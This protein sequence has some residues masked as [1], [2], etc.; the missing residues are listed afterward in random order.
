MLIDALWLAVL[1]YI[2]LQVLVLVKAP[3]T[4]DLSSL[5]RVI[6]LC[7]G[8]RLD[9]VSRHTGHFSIESRAANLRR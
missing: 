8:I 9:S 3:P 4:H 5:A 7:S 2:V 1:A 6:P